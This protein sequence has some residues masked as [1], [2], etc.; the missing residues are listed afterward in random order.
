MTREHKATAERRRALRSALIAVAEA[1]IDREGLNALSARQISTDVGCS[2]GAIYNVFEDLD[3]LVL[4]VNSS[5]LAR[6]DR[7]IVKALSN[8]ADE[9]DP[10]D[11]LIAIGH[12]YCRFAIAHTHLWSALFEQGLKTG[13][14]TPDWHM[15]EH[16]RLF[17]HIL[18]CLK[19]LAP[20]QSDEENWSLARLLFSAVHGAVSLGIQGFF[21]AIPPEDLERQVSTLITAV[22]RGLFPQEARRLSPGR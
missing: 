18:T 10:M 8:A 3:A 22:A 2:L 4:A 5:T 15:D 16:L 19:Q 6:L 17:S 21:V 13:R 9:R 7:Q 14:A 12:A 20:D 1:R 11:D